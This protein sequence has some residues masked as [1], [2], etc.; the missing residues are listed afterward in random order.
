MRDKGR[1]RRRWT[2]IMRDIGLVNASSL[3]ILNHALA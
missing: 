1:S 2:K 3:I